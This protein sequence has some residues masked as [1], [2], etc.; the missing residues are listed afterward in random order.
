LTK[1]LDKQ[2]FKTPTPV[3]EAV[4]PPAIHGHDILASAQTG[5]GKTLAFTLPLLQRLYIAREARNLP[6]GPI[7]RKI[8]ALII[9]PTRE[10][11]GQI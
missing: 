10:L 8:E 4:I 7:K 1:A 6:D 2:G 5:S 3:Q 11:A 9:A